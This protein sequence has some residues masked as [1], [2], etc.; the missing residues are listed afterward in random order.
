M[1]R[2]LQTVLLLSCSAAAMAGTPSIPTELTPPA[3]ARLVLKTH[4]T[5]A[6]VYTCKAA[7]DGKFQWVL[8]APDAQLHD[9]KG[10]VIGQHFAGPTWKHKD[11]S[12]VIAKAAAHVDSP[13]AA[14]VPWLLLAATGHTGEGVFSKVSSIQ[15][16]N[17][18][19]GKPS[20]TV[21]CDRSKEGTQIRSPYAADYYFYAGG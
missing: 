9:R 21:Q 3:R 5:G 7:D 20:A 13:D 1:T 4:A 18:K 2:V 14:S 15:R 10:A 12:Q 11:G 17:T 8:Q 6:Q 16:I 19:G